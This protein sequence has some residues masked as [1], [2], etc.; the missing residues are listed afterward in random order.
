MFV[1][2]HGFSRAVQDRNDEGFSPW[3]TA[4]LPSAES[5]RSLLVVYTGPYTRPDPAIHEPLRT[6]SVVISRNLG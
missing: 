4:W 5:F 1:S 3:G 6:G 2:G